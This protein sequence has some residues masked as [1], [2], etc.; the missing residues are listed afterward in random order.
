MT[1][2]RSKNEK[3]LFFE[4]FATNV[5]SR[6]KLRDLPGCKV[7]RNKKGIEETNGKGESVSTRDMKKFNF[8]LG[9]FG[10]APR[11]KKTWFSFLI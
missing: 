7:T 9:G 1:K 5:L 6:T 8:N 4:N 11:T 10:L 2:L 3:V